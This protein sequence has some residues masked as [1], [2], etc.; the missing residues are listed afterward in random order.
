MAIVRLED[1]ETP[2]D[3][4]GEAAVVAA[5]FLGRPEYVKRARE[6]VSPDV[7]YS[8]RHRH[9]WRAVMAL[10]DAG[11]PIDHPSVC[12]WLQDDGRLAQV[13]G[14]AYVT[15]VLRSAAVVNSVSLVAHAQRVR[16]LW[17]RRQVIAA[18]QNIIGQ[19]YARQLDA[20]Q[21]LDRMREHIELLSRKTAAGSN[22]LPLINLTEL[23]QPLP[24]VP[25][26]CAD[27]GIAPGPPVLFAGYGYS[28]KTM[29]VQDM[30]LSVAAG[31]P[32]WNAYPC[33]QGRALHIDYE[34]G[35][36]LTQ[37]RYQRLA[38][39][40][41]FELSSLPADAFALSCMP[42]VYLDDREASSV[43]ARAFEG[44]AL[45]VIDSLR[46][47]CPGADENSSEIRRYLDVLTRAAE[48]TGA[49]VVVIHHARKPQKDD[50]GG[51]KFA[52][53]GSSSLFDACA[54]VF[55]FTGDKG[56]ATTVH[57]EKDRI[58]GSCLDDFR[59]DAEDVPDSDENPRDRKWGLRIIHIPPE[60]VSAVMPGAT[61]EKKLAMV[62]R[63]IVEVLRTRPGLSG[64]SICE[65]I[66]AR[67]Q[68][69]LAALERMTLKG[70]VRCERKGRNVNYRLPDVIDMGVS[71]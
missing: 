45:V 28:R 69:V 41:G 2:Y 70:E 15:D 56:E 7:F 4:D 46:A 47:A 18:C 5:A 52:I 23:A 19:G 17:V 9:I 14:P 1:Q 43:F 49:V 63:K 65:M 3:L 62:E 11:Q 48:M 53:R 38:R 39:A 57:H 10:E 42:R 34:Q 66:E 68:V 67:R 50:P 59:L 30:V 6:I 27:L 12:A 25:Y 60:K 35:R 71:A 21:M 29:A 44:Y 8:E 26:L 13:G 37:E 20:T 55:V 22:P 31:I 40:R 58:R 51:A 33:R 36:Y 64:G 16:E 24:P 54:S 61:P 32:I